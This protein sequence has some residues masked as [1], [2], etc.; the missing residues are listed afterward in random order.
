MG[1]FGFEARQA[2]AQDASQIRLTMS[3]DKKR[4]RTYYTFSSPEGMTFGLEL[5]CD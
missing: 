3:D 1:V 5:S 2:V 4:L